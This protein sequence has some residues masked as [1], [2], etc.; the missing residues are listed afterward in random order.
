MGR[1]PS[2]REMTREEGPAAVL[3][4]VVQRK[5]QVSLT[6]L[7]R[8]RILVLLA[9]ARESITSESTVPHAGHFRPPPGL[10]LMV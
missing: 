9:T 10:S 4:H 8:L 6:H 7:R 2:P 3:S 1:G 5:P